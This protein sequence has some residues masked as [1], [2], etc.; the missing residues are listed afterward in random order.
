MKAALLLYD[1]VLSALQVVPL[2]SEL[3]LLDLDWRLRFKSFIVTK[4]ALRLILY[5][6]IKLVY[7]A[8]RE[9]KI[10]PFLSLAFRPSAR[11]L[12]LTAGPLNFSFRPSP[13][14]P[15]F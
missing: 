13:P 5:V 12:N 6:P 2:P 10:A 3:V 15:S 9:S 14:K 4:F 7:S 1:F 11:R 8:L